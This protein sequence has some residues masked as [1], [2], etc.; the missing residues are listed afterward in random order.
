MCTSTTPRGSCRCLCVCQRCSFDLRADF[1]QL[2]TVGKSQVWES[3]WSMHRLF[4]T[5]SNGPTSLEAGHGELTALVHI[6]FTANSE[7]PCKRNQSCSWRLNPPAGTPLVLKALK[8]MSIS[9]KSGSTDYDTCGSGLSSLFAIPTVTIYTIQRRSQAF[10]GVRPEPL[11]SA[12]GWAGVGAAPT[13]PG[14]VAAVGPDR[15]AAPA[16]VLTPLRHSALV[17]VP[18]AQRPLQTARGT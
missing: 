17:H 3:C 1:T 11:Q 6:L 10:S 13:C 16:S 9:M 12:P 14:A 5:K 18:L 4:R 8:K 7:K 2:A 15:V